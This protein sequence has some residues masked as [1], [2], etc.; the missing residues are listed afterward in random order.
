M[1]IIPDDAFVIYVTAFGSAGVSSKMTAAHP[2]KGL[3]GTPW[4]AC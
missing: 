2:I 4:Y 3:R 1:N